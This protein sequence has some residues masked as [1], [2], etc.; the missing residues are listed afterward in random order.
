MGFVR[1]NKGSLVRVDS[2]EYVGEKG[3]LFWDIETGCSRISDGVT[4]GGITIE[5]CPG[6]SGGPPVFTNSLPVGSSTI[7]DSVP[8][9]IHLGIKWIYTLSNPTT[10]EVLTAEVIANHK[11]ETDV[12]YSI[13]GMVGDIIQHTTN[14]ILTGTPTNIALEI[15]NNSADILQINVVRIQMAS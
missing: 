3:Y 1:K 10:H 9:D 15:T 11:F 8:A 5:N 7:I 13:Y 4:P 14:V 2:T 12:R 6:G